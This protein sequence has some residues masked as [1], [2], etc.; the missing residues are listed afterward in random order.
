MRLD[1]N[2]SRGEYLLNALTNSV[3]LTGSEAYFVFHVLLYW[4]ESDGCISGNQTEK[5]E[6]LH[7]SEQRRFS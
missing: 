5:M 1:P 4:A 6:S 3:K 7:Y 2:R